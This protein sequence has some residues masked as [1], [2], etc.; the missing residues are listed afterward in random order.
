MLD[1]TVQPSAPVARS[2]RWMVR[3]NSARAAWAIRESV[4]ALGKI[5]CSAA[6]GRSGHTLVVRHLVSGLVDPQEAEISCLSDFSIFDAIID[7]RLISGGA[8]LPEEV[9]GMKGSVISEEEAYSECV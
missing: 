3:L 8:E 6:V 1:D 2:S 7:E 9:S 5:W 4:G